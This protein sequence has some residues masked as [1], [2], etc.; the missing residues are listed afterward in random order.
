MVFSITFQLNH[1][2]YHTKRAALKSLATRACKAT[3]SQEGIAQA[4]LSVLLTDDAAIRV[5]N[6]DFRGKDKATNVLAFPSDEAG[7]LGDIAVSLDTTAVEAA[8]QNKTFEHHLTHLLVHACLH[9]LGHDHM[10]KAEAAR[11]EKKEIAILQQLNIKN[12]YL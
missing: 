5:L 8:A 12:P 3:L 2:A 11:M 7:Y 10:K 6:H 4:E 1:S 9:L